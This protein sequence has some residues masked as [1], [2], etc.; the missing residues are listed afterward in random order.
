LLSGVRIDLLDAK[1]NI[2][3]TTHTN[4]QGEYR[5]DGLRAGEYQVVEHQPAGYYDG[6]ERV[7]SHGGT[8]DGIDTIYNINLDPGDD[9]VHYDFCEKVGVSLSGYVYH[10]RSNDGIFDR[11]VPNP[12]TGISGVVLKLLD[13][14]GNDTGKRATTDGNG[15]YIFNDLKAGTYSVM[16]I[17]P[18]GWLDGLDTP[19]NSGGAAD[20]PPPGDMISQLTL[21]WGHPGVEYNFGEL[22]PGSIR[23]RVHADEHEDCNF[24][25]PDVFLEGVQIDLLDAQGN[26][27]ATTHTNAAGEYAF[28]DLRPG[29]YSVR[30]HQPTSHFDGGERVGSAGGNK[31]DVPGEFSF[32]TDINITSGLNAIQYD[33]CEKPGAEI[34]GYVYIDGAPIVTDD[35]LTPEQIAAQRDGFRTADD[36]PLGGVVLELR[37]PGGDPIWVEQALAG[38]YAGAPG[39]PIRVTTDAKGFYR[40]TGLPAGTY[41]VVQIQPEGVIDNV[42]H[43]GT[44]GGYAVNPVPTSTTPAGIPAGAQSIVNQFR[45]QFGNNAIVQIALRNGQHAQEN[46]FS[47]VVTAP[48]PPPPPPPVP[49]V[50]PTPPPPERP[51]FPPQLFPYL[52]RPSA[53]LLP[54]T[55]LPF[56]D[57]SHA[58]GF[59]WHLSVVNAGQPRSINAQEVR[60][61][62]TSEVDWHNVQL[63]SGRWVMATLYDN[64]VAVIREE[65]FGT[66]DALPVTG[67]YNGDGITDIGVYIDGHWY[68]DLDGNGHWD[69]RDLWAH[70][71]SQDDLPV[72]GDWDADGKTD[73]GIYGPA[74]P[75]DP[76]AISREPGL[77]DTANF[78]TLPVGKMKNMPPT[79]EDATSGARVMKRTEHGKRRAD[80][81]DHV[82]HYGVPA[83]VPVAGDWNGDG[84][85]QIGVFRDGQWNLDTNG[86]GRLTDDDGSAIFG[87]AGDKPVVGDF[88]G[89]GIDEIGVFRAGQW[90]LD[91]NHNH[92]LD[93]QDKVFELGAAGDLPV[94]G[95]WND[96]GKDDPGVYQPGASTD[97]VARRA[98]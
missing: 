16:E 85:R 15:F 54:A 72:T 62:F 59:T 93:A 81:I 34:S 53:A 2:V 6:G 79:A 94:V 35:P 91:T 25:D 96:D 63:T 82:F 46:N 47:E 10:D 66:D 40:F 38:H 21:R 73:I 70:L 95:D 52:R 49:P 7:G 69:E 43:P 75:R 50:P 61:Q 29:T 9:A 60:F 45:E 78:P 92:E 27:I 57:V 90:F 37:G 44:L 14:D 1:G 12:E 42:D 76:W 71:G 19:G 97:R 8:R 24:D 5:F 20:N 17:H 77:P 28:T 64:Q 68:L 13:A 74:W 31:H 86:D 32:F 3:A 51:V 23:G 39:T 89:D 67:D 55:P 56:G 83:D 4:A 11:T 36:T 65:I 84:V 48:E 88:D 87:Q 41:A 80:L 26:V 98:G 18:T 58:L 30:E 22:L 33:F